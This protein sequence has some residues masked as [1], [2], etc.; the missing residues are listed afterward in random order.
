MSELTATDYK[1]KGARKRRKNDKKHLQHL[2][3]LWEKLN[4]GYPCPV[5]PKDKNRE[6]NAEEPEYYEREWRGQRSKHIKKKCNEQLRN[7]DEEELFRH[8]EYKKKS[9]FW[10][11]YC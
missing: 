2:K 8:G 6:Y 3:A 10:W 9:D 4:G 5:T 11:D 7:S 1:K